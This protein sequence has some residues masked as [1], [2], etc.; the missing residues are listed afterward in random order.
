MV[1]KVQAWCSRSSES[2]GSSQRGQRGKEQRP[3]SVESRRKQVQAEATGAKRCARGH[4]PGLPGDTVP[5]SWGTPARPP[6]C[7]PLAP[8]ISTRLSRGSA[9]PPPLP[10]LWSHGC[11]RDRTTHPSLLT[12]VVVGCSLLSSPGLPLG[13]QG[14]L[15][16]FFFVGHAHGLQK[17]PDQGLNPHHSSNPRCCSDNTGS[18]TFCTTRELLRAP[19]LSQKLSSS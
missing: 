16:F 11:R 8:L 13:A 15:L 3:H 6:A 2:P 1:N 14:F 17:F 10:S 7:G 4:A 19:F 9:P 5:S 18:L 12:A